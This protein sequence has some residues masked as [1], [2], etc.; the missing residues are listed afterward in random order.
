VADVG[1]GNERLARIW[2]AWADSGP[3][4]WC[5]AAREKKHMKLAAEIAGGC[6]AGA[7]I[8]VGIG[9]TWVRFEIL[10]TQ[11]KTRG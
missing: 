1:A 7:V 11:R 4:R 6:F 5:H 8:W 10:K 3:I 9:L 2:N